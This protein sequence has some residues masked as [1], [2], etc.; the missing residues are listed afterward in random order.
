MQKFF[1][2]MC[3]SEATLI[4]TEVIKKPSYSGG[5]GLELTEAV[6]LEIECGHCPLVSASF[7]VPPGTADF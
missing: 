3:G 4:S 2:P 7:Q 6:Q 1:C 5:E